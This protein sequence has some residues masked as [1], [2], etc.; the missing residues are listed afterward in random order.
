MRAIKLVN[1]LGIFSVVLNQSAISPLSLTTTEHE[2]KIYAPKQR[3][4][5]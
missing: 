3:K 5:I 4:N 1:I 2:V